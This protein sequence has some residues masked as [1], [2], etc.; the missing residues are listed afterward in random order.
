[1][2]AL[3]IA[4]T[5]TASIHRRS[6]SLTHRLGFTQQLPRSL[7]FATLLI[8]KLPG[9]T[10]LARTFVQCMAQPQAFTET[11][12]NL[13]QLNLASEKALYRPTSSL[14]KHVLLLIGEDTAL[15][16]LGTL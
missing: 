13:L 7:W 10:R 8:T 15:R 16:A 6:P 14:Q 11:M 12:E 4:A 9:S 1:M 3:A 5:A 2:L